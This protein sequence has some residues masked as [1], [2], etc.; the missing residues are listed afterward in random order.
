MTGVPAPDTAQP[1]RTCGA[2]CAFS[3]SWPRFSTE[4]DEALALIPPA[5]VADNGSG[6]RCE[7]ERCSALM[8]VVGTAVGCAIYAIRPDVCRACLPGDDA[9]SAARQAF[10][11]PL[12]EAP[13]AGA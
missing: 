3:Y 8:G 7:G 5:L 13:A 4:S 1:C 6:M 10:G 11:L 12:I 9:C 2:C